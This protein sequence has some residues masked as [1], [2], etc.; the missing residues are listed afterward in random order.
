MRMSDSPGFLRRG[1]ISPALHGTLDYLL[2]A[3]LIAAPLVLHFHDETAKVVMLVLGG[4]A[5]V[6]AIGTNWSRGIVHVI[7][8]AVHG[9]ADIGATIALIIAPFVFGFSEHTLALVIYVA[10]GAGGLLATLLT[11][12]ESDLPAATRTVHAPSP[13]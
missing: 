10:V 13:I 7:P 12:F 11:R 3:T 6:L 8:P 2:A 4:A 9:V 1:P 5:A